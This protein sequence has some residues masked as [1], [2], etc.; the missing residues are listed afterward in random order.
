MVYAVNSGFSLA[1]K[2]WPIAGAGIFMILLL[3]AN[4]IAQSV[5]ERIPEFAVLETLG[6]P[7]TTLMAM[8]F[9]ETLIPCMTGA[10]LGTGLADLLTRLPAHY[11]PGDLS[12]IPQPTLSP[13]VL[14]WSIGCALLLAGASAL[15]PMLRLRQL[16]VTDAL[17]GH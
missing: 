1:K 2:T 15:A 7:G 8:V 10:V 9:T 11:L 6:Y 16:S 13:Q 4:G 12:G 17:A 14:A 3:T 5:R